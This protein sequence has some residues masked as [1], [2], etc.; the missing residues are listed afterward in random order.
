MISN[1]RY[2][3]RITR[4]DKTRADTTVYLITVFRERINTTVYRQYCQYH[5]QAYLD[6]ILKS[7]KKEISEYSAAAQI[8]MNSKESIL[9]EYVYHEKGLV[10][11]IYEVA[12]YNIDSI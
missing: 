2:E 8:Y 9:Y 6:L 3:T 5:N 4:L 11:Q 10:F 1:T 12:V 7:F